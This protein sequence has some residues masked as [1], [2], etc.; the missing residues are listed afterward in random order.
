[1]K[2]RKRGKKFIESENL[3]ESTRDAERERDEERKRAPGDL[4][5]VCFIPIAS[6]RGVLITIFFQN[7]QVGRE[8]RT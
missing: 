7:R 2:K 5:N 1:M 3:T 6:Y 4:Y 8:I